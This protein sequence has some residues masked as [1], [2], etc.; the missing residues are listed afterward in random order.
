MD[1]NVVDYDLIV[2]ENENFVEEK[3][4]KGKSWR[5]FDNPSSLSKNEKSMKLIL[6]KLHEQIPKWR[7]HGRNSSTHDIFLALTMNQKLTWKSYKSCII[8]YVMKN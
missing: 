6:K 1:P 5:V 2:N 3:S 4:K 7:P 8:C